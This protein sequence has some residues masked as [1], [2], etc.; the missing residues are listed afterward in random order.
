MENV[1]AVSFA[2]ESEAYQAM[3][4][5]KKISINELFVISQA[6]LIKKVAGRIVTE[7]A[8]DTGINTEDDTHIGG[9]IGGLVGIVGGPVGMLLSGSIGALTG[10]VVDSVQ[11]NHGV[12]MIEKVADQF[13]DG[14]T[15]IVMLVQE[16]TP[17]ALDL[18]LSKYSAVVIRAD[19]AEV[20]EEIKYAQDMER[21]LE[22]EAR[23]KLREEKKE[24]H[25]QAV[26]ER[27]AKMK[28]DFEELKKKFSKE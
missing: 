6:A 10:S 5:L 13:M 26:E 22:K 27:R 17:A 18:E 8:F 9:L 3:S 12:T 21:E 24:E 2:I 16:K 20:A 28:S 15:G 7:D 11:A 25:K 4:S 19:A 23:K 14:E 1:V